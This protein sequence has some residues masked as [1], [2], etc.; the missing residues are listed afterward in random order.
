M[1]K[2]QDITTDLE[3]SKR[4]K[5]KGFPQDSLF[6]HR[7]YDCNDDIGKNI[8]ERVEVDFHTKLSYDRYIPSPTAE[9]I[10]KELPNFIGMVSS[11]GGRFGGRVGFT[12][13]E[14]FHAYLMWWGKTNKPKCPSHIINDKKLC[15]ALALMWIYLKDNN[16]LEN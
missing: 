4:L 2:L 6:F 11:G 12:I 8:V 9:E 16:L 3:I 7:L 10:L 5:E 1:D 13:L 14:E 15:N